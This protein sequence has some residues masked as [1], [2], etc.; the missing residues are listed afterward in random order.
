MGQREETNLLRMFLF[1]FDCL[2]LLNHSDLMESGTMN[3]FCSMFYFGLCFIQKWNKP[4]TQIQLRKVCLFLLLNWKKRG[5]KKNHSPSPFNQK[6]N[7]YQGE[8]FSLQ[9]PGPLGVKKEGSWLHKL[10]WIWF[11]NRQQQT[12]VSRRKFQNISSMLRS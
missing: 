2:F 10:W 7:K 9:H 8:V 6:A 12:P 5:G 1:S 3:L 11:D 4:Q